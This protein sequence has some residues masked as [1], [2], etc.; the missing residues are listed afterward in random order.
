[1]IAKKR[2]DFDRA[3]KF[4]FEALNIIKVEHYFN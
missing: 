4:Y 2:G 3:E 1:M